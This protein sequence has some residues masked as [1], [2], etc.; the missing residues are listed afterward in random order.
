[1][2]LIVN[3]LNDFSKRINALT[4]GYAYE[5]FLETIIDMEKD[6]RIFDLGDVTPAMQFEIAKMAITQRPVTVEL[7]INKET[8]IV[9]TSDCIIPGEPLHVIFQKRSFSE[10]TFL[11]TQ[12][13]F[14]LGIPGYSHTES[15]IMHLK[16]ILSTSH[17]KGGVREKN[18]DLGERKVRI[19]SYNFYSDETYQMFVNNHLPDMTIFFEVSHEDGDD[20][21]FLESMRLSIWYA[22]SPVRQLLPPGVSSVFNVSRL[23]FEMVSVM[24]NITQELLPISQMRDVEQMLISDLTN[25]PFKQVFGYH[26]ITT[27]VNETITVPWGEITDLAISATLQKLSKDVPGALNDPAYVAVVLKRDMTGQN[28]LDELIR[29]YDGVE[30]IPTIQQFMMHTSGLTESMPESFFRGFLDTMVSAT[31]MMTKTRLFGFLPKF[32]RDDETLEAEL[33]VMLNAV[34]SV[35]KLVPGAPFRLNITGN[36]IYDYAILAMLIRRMG[37]DLKMSAQE[38]IAKT[39]RFKSDIHWNPQISS[40]TKEIIGGPLT[41][42]TMRNGIFSTLKTLGLFMESLTRDTSIVES[43]IIDRVLDISS[44]AADSTFRTMVWQGRYAQENPIPIFFRRSEISPTVVYMAPHLG[45]YGAL[46]LGVDEVA[47]KGMRVVD[48]LANQVVDRLASMAKFVGHVAADTVVGIIEV[49]G[50]VAKTTTDSVAAVSRQPSIKNI[51]PVDVQFQ[52]PFVS[53][54]SNAPK[55]LTFKASQESVNTRIDV[56]RNDGSIESRLFL[57]HTTGNVHRMGELVGPN[58][59]ERVIDPTPVIIDHSVYHGRDGIYYSDP[60]ISEPHLKTISEN[61]QSF[62]ARLHQT[63][64]KNMIQSGSGLEVSDINPLSQESANIPFYQRPISHCHG[65]KHHKSYFDQKHQLPVS[66]F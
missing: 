36:T 7:S 23:P 35:E 48:I 52:S 63:P 27:H 12:F 49:G 45:L 34:K 32:T 5:R 22:P 8:P 51:L 33:V 19:F 31:E 15:G 38:V 11:P 56:V 65:K 54:V 9:M 26:G 25:M 42:Y 20:I 55:L 47:T 66:Q 40:D 64:I 59:I 2:A 61:I 17:L 18:S 16:E 53:T 58:T 29:I 6:S 60:R 10:H 44:E 28:V 1:M 62:H 30:K 41:I 21:L 43:Q 13:S 46:S 14:T 24:P 37:G 57:D 39:L 4:G 50:S 3:S